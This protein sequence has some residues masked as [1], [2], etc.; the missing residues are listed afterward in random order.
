MRAK[1]VS[2]PEEIVEPRVPRARARRSTRRSIRRPPPLAPALIRNSFAPGQCVEEIAFAGKRYFLGEPLAKSPSES[3]FACTDVWGNHLL[4]KTLSPGPPND[5]ALKKESLRELRTLMRLRHPFITDVLDVFEYG[6]VLYLIVERCS[7][8]LSDIIAWSDFQGEVWLKPIARCVL[9]AIDFIHAAGHL[10]RNIH[11]GNI[12]VRS[13]SS[14]ISEPAFMPTFKLGDWVTSL[15]LK[16]TGALNTK[17]AEWMA[18]PEL[19]NPQEFGT[20]GQ[21]LDIYQAGLLLLT[22]LLGEMPSF[23]I[24]EILAGKPQQMAKALQA[25]FGPAI[26]RALRC[27]TIDRTPTPLDF[28]NDLQACDP[29]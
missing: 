23:T 6:G 27:H 21:P 29:F 9:Q 8:T 18:P 25:T 19:L 11:A 10:H 17:V 3:I 22:V 20:P 26:A 1:E 12:F 24:E 28:W 15:L 2:A 13:L 16:P 4:A 7:F 14:K 5:R